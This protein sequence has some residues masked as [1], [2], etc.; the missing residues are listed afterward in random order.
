MVAVTCM[1]VS[2]WLTGNCLACL[3]LV[4]KLSQ[5]VQR[6]LA[7]IRGGFDWDCKV[8]RSL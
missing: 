6:M 2:Q 7:A 5:P 8:S 3:M 4:R 1:I